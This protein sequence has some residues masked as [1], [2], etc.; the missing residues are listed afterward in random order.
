MM[1]HGEGRCP[2]P[3][4]GNERGRKACREPEHSKLGLRISEAIED[5][6]TSE[7]T[8]YSLGSVLNSPP[9]PRPSSF[10]GRNSSPSQARIPDVVVD[11]G[12]GSN[13]AASLS[14]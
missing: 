6:V 12:W 3:E 2:Q 9:C 4:P 13:F 10:E 11:G 8:K 7:G 5:A 14:L 1:R